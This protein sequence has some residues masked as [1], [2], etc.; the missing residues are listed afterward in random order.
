MHDGVA[1]TYGSLDGV[2]NA[3][4]VASSRLYSDSSRGDI[5]QLGER[6]VR[7]AEVWGSSPHI[8]TTLPP[9]LGIYEKGLV[10]TTGFEPVT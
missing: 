8:S 2:V 5:A 9:N 4:T 10:A 7:N 6:R 3:L 1:L